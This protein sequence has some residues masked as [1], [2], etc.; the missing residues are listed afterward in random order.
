MLAFA[1]G[2]TG[3]RLEAEPSLEDLVAALMRVDPDAAAIVTW[4]QIRVVITPVWGSDG[5]D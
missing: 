5:G 3:C 2:Q 4:G 1:L